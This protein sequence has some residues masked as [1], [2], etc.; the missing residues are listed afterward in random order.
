MEFMAA[1]EGEYALPSRMNG[2]HIEVV[3]ASSTVHIVEDIVING[4]IRY[5]VTGAGSCTLKIT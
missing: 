5:I 1:K 4:S 2:K 3:K